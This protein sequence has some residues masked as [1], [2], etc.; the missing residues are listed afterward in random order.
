MTPPLWDQRLARALVRPLVPTPV[1]PNLITALGLG[2]G[3]GAAASFAAGRPAW[4]GTLYVLAALADHA[5]GE[6]ARLSGKSSRWGHVFDRV[7]SAVTTT[8]VFV[9]MGL[10]L[11]EAWFGSWGVA[12][13]LAAGAGVAALFGL[14]NLGERRAGAVGQGRRAGFEAEDVLYLIGPLAWFGWHG[15][16]LVLAAIGAPAYLAL[17]LIRAAVR[18]RRQA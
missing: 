13:G 15:W 6:L 16:F 7:A 2:L 1:G 18:R 14:A 9:G 10:G 12:L 4:G 5:D 17:V 3:L 11:D 8:L